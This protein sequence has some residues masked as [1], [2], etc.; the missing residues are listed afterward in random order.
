M[1]IVARTIKMLPRASSGHKA[2][3]VGGKRVYGVV[4][5]LLFGSVNVSGDFCN[6]PRMSRKLR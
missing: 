5:K 2:N 3:N 4:G 1:V 6:P